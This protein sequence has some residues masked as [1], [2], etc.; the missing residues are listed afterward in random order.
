[1]NHNDS[2]KHSL[3]WTECDSGPATDH[4]GMDSYSDFLKLNVSGTKD[5]GAE[6]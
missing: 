1:M 2:V 4:M 6:R 3:I 5:P